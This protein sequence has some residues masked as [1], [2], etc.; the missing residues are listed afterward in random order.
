MIIKK[1]KIQHMFRLLIGL[2]VTLAH[3]IIKQ[4]TFLVVALITPHKV[5]IHKINF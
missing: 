4:K 5:Q 3:Q 1:N 2:F